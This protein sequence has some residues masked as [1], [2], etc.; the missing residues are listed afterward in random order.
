MIALT[1]HMASAPVYLDYQATTPLD[2]RVRDAMQP[3]LQ[4]R[5]GNPHAIHHAYGWNAARA[6][7]EGRAQVAAL[8]GADDQEIIFASGATESCNIALRGTIKRSTG[9]NEII[10]VATEHPA[11]LETVRALGLDGVPIRK[12]GVNPD[13]IMD[14]DEMQDA[15]SDKTAIVSAML[16]NNEIGV[17]HPVAEI[18]SIAH[19]HGALMHTDATQAAGK[20]GIDVDSLG[21]DLLSLSSH[22]VYGPMGIGVLYVHNDTFDRIGPVAT[23]GGQERGLRPGTLPV[24]L[25][26]GFGAACEIA[27]NETEK[28][29]LRIRKLTSRL[30]QLLQKS[31]PGLQL[32]GHKYQRVPG[33][34]NVSFPGISGD[35][36]I[37]G[38]EGSVAISTGSACSS[39]GVEPSHVLTALGQPPLSALQ[40]VRI[41]L[42]RFTTEEDIMLAALAFERQFGEG[43]AVA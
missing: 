31:A 43:V 40:A 27:L 15:I 3:F 20:I 39:R 4:E 26:V 25:V 19:E 33:S 34:L 12:I 7:A 37:A 35:E 36:V 16:V 24:H 23:G 21:I 1:K 13:G 2:P 42:G 41:S 30:W 9:R 29:S 14:M 28:D 22:K 18:A 8:L 11:V 32:N 10:T 6:V 17:V 38:L 5:F